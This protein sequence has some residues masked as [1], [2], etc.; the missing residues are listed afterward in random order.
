MAEKFTSVDDYLDSFGGEVRDRLDEVRR[1]FVE[2]LP[3]AT[4]VISYNIPAYRQDDMFV[5]YF[6]GHQGHISIACYPTERLFESLHDEL[7]PYKKSKSAFQLPHSQPLPVSLLR[8]VALFK[9]SDNAAIKAG[10]VG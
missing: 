2:A 8:R 9:V 3:D 10:T 5:V 7:A 6:S 4:E 1:I